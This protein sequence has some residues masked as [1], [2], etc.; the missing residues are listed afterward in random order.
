M[1]NVLLA[2]DHQ[3][4][5]NGLGLI[6]AHEGFEI[7]G[8]VSN[9]DTLITKALNVL[10]DVIISDLRMPG[11]SILKSCPEIKQKLPK[12]KVVVLTAFEESEDIYQAMEAGIDGYILKNT[13]PEEII[14]TVRMVM[15]GYSCFQPKV[16]KP[17]ESMLLK[18]F[19]LT[20]REREVFELIIENHSNLEIAEKLFISEPTVKSHVSS[21]LR[22]TGQANRSQAV[23]HAL[24]LGYVKVNS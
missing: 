4:V 16:R 18:D 22:K 6:L 3:I 7:V 14:K 19:G 8:D 2:D 13:D 15:M 11:A 5:K 17:V 21:I 12:V 20:D 23:I 24:K 10:P 9:G 1:V